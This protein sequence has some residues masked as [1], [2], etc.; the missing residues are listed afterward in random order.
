[1]SSN[2]APETKSGTA[3]QFSGTVY[4]HIIQYIQI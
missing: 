2:K 1:M 4:Y 3:Q